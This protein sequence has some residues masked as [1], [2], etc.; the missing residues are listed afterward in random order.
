[1]AAGVDDVAVA[2][3]VF[4]D[5]LRNVVRVGDEII[6]AVG[7]AFVPHAQLVHLVGHD[8]AHQ[9]VGVGAVGVVKVPHIAD[10]RVAVADVHGVRPRDDALGA[11]RRGGQHEVILRQVQRLERAGHQR[12]QVFVQFGGKGQFLHP[13]GADVIALEP[14]GHLFFIVHQRVDHSVGEHMVHAVH[15]AVA[16][17]I[18][19]QPVVYDGYF[20]FG[21]AH[22]FP[23]GLS[24]HWIF[25]LLIILPPNTV[26]K[27]ILMSSATVQ[28]SMYQIS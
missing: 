22:S 4:F 18:G 25:S 8:G 12:Q 27:M 16:A 3:V 7:G 13:G 11:G 9:P 28:F 6:D 15:H 24:G 5:A 1:M 10:G 26:R 23:P 2:A 19:H 21:L 17:G 14:R 20:R